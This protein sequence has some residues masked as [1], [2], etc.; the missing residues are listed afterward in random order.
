LIEFTLVGGAAAAWPLAARAQQAAMPVVGYLSTR[1]PDD[2]PYILAS[3][4]QGLKDVGFI[5]RR[6]VA[7]SQSNTASPRTRMIG[8]PH[9]RATWSDAK[10]L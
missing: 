8:C 3:I 7:T 10:W 2:D 9:W 1:G 6:N 4:R 5:E